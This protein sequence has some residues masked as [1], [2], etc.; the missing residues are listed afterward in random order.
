MKDFVSTIAIRPQ[1]ADALIK[2]IDDLCS[3]P[4]ALS[5]RGPF[6]SH[7]TRELTIQLRVGFISPVC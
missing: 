4:V 6:P 3:F 7:G 2:Q 1:T 5:A